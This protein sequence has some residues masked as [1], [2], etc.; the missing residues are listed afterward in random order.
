MKAALLSAVCILLTAACSITTISQLS[1]EGSLTYVGESTCSTCHAKV[2]DSFKTHKHNDAYTKLTNNRRYL[3][4]A[5]EGR[6]GSCLKCH[7]TGYGEAGGFVNPEKTPKLARV[8]C[9]ACHGPGSR[10]AMARNGAKKS[11][12]QRKPDC[13]RCHLIHTHET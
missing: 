4:L 12:I 11:T 7:V 5:D 10:H 13:G 9:E 8:S 1:Q 2:A 3:K 6:E